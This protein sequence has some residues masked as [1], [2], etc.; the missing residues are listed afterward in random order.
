LFFQK[1]YA[2]AW[3]KISEAEKLGGKTIDK[4]FIADLKKKMRRP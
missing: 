4:K 3:K 1:D 2:G